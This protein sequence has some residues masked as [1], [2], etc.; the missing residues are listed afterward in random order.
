MAT[1]CEGD[2]L[3]RFI[4]LPISVRA[5]LLIF[6]MTLVIA[7]SGIVLLLVLANNGSS[8]RETINEQIQNGIENFHSTLH[9]RNQQLTSNASLLVSDFGFKRAVATDDADTIDSM[10]RNHGNRIKADVMV[11]IDLE[12]QIITSTNLTF[13]RGDAFGHQGVTSKVSQGEM[14][15]DFLI[16]DDAIYHMALVPV[17]TPRI[18]AIA[19]IGFRVEPEG[20]REWL[21]EPNLHLTYTNG[22]PGQVDPWVVATSLPDLSS[23]VEAIR[24]PSELTHIVRLPFQRIQSFINREITMPSGSSNV[25]VF[26]SQNLQPYFV[27]YDVIRNQILFVASL[28][29]MAG[30]VG[31]L[32]LGRRLTTPLQILTTKTREVARGQY[33]DM[34]EIPTTS[35]DVAA[36]T[37]AFRR[38]KHD[39][40]ERESR[41]QYQASHDSLTG[42]LNRDSMKGAINDVVMNDRPFLLLGLNLVGFK[43]INDTLGTEIGDECL[44]SFAQRIRGVAMDGIACRSSVDEFSLLLPITH[45]QIATAQK[46]LMCQRVLDDVTAPMQIKDMSLTIDYCAG[47][48]I[49]PEQADSAEQLLRRGKVALEHAITNSIRLYYFREGQDK[50]QLKKVKILRHLK[51]ALQN[52]DDQLQMF[53]QPKYNVH[54]GQVD[55]AE[56]LIRWFHPDEGFIPPDMFIEL[57]EQTGLIGLVTAWVI[58]RVFDDQAELKRSG[59]SLQLSINLS[60]QD[61]SDDNL[62]ILIDR[63]LMENNLN[64]ADICLEV[65]ERDM[66]TDVDKS[67]DLLNYYRS[68]GFRLSIDDYGVGYSALSKL[69]SMPVHELKIDKS[70]IIRLASRTDDQIIVRSTISMAHELGLSIIAEGVEDK[71]SLNFLTELGCDYIQGYFIAKPMARD[72]LGQWLNEFNADLLMEQK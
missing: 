10:L 48:V 58:A 30:V 41:M 33:G 46:I 67:L 1:R 25:R 18:S 36:L 14:F 12:G 15:S 2:P 64:A 37:T 40:S 27:P 19:G 59:I 23:V 16:N 21:S 31:S 45:D 39:L 9:V 65:T 55:K 4:K 22:L 72:G 26:M 60:A 3:F 47:F 51:E 49:Y 11:I 8:I 34:P 13:G 42:L 17:R 63:K 6:V 69:A 44:I 5:Q 29:L 61:L 54:T 32:V 7:S 35:S 24:A 43:T 56:A 66:M 57:A 53:Y 62:R 70:F 20:L 50:I 71:E 38:M 52:D 28:V 68:R